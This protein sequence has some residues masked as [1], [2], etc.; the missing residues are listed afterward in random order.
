MSAIFQ[1]K[2]RL[3]N[4]IFRYLACS[5][6]CIK[7]NLEYK[8][9]GTHNYVINDKLFI[10]W[11]N[12]DKENKKLRFKKTNFLFNGYYQHDDIYIKYKKELLEY[13]HINQNHILTTD[14]IKAGDRQFQ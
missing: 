14:G 9:K 3:G 10:N 7:Y 12:S 4:A 2:G 8:N 6:F 11:I 1:I 5:L 13:M